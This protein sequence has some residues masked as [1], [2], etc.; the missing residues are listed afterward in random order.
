M[1]GGEAEREEDGGEREGGEGGGRGSLYIPSPART[2][3]I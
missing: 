3:T 2:I 1:G